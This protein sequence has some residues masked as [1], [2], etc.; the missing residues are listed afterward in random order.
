MI[1]K[2]DE[3]DSSITLFQSGTAKKK[4]LESI[5]EYGSWRGNDSKFKKGLQTSK[6]NLL[7]NTGSSLIGIMSPNSNYDIDS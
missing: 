5:K 1:V 7:K 3:R 6:R 2:K 4:P